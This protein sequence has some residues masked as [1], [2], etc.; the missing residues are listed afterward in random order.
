MSPHYTLP[1][2]LPVVVKWPPCL[3]TMISG[4]RYAI[5]G[6]TWIE[7]PLDTTREQLDQYMIV[8][9]PE[10]KKVEVWEVDGSR[11]DTYKVN[12][13]VSAGKWSC[14]C[15]GFRWRGACKHIKAIEAKRAFQQMYPLQSP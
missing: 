7:V 11:G 15:P 9:R 13:D 6:S 1:Y 10:P 14:T 2:T 12:F 3:A 8:E 5:S 4:K